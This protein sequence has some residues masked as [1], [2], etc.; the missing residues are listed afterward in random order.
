MRASFWLIFLKELSQTIFCSS[1]ED[2]F[3]YFFFLLGVLGLFLV[4]IA[5]N[6]L[7]T[8]RNG[9]DVFTA[10]GQAGGN[11]FCVCII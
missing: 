6:F 9:I 2:L 5:T 8:Y 7:L 4:K 1:G 10:K 11:F 3:A